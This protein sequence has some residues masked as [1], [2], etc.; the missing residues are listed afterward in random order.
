MRSR[1]DSGFFAGS[2]ATGGLPLCWVLAGDSPEAF[3]AAVSVFTFIISWNELLDTVT[4][5]LDG[6][7]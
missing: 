4:V 6:A 7:K 3:G 2:L 1:E 5:A